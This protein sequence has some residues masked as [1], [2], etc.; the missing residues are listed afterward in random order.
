MS[1][2]RHIPKEPHSLG[3]PPELMTR[4][5]HAAADERRSLS[6]LV[7]EALCQRLGIDPARY[8]I[9]PRKPERKAHAASRQ[10]A[11]DRPA[12]RRP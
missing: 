6:E 4:V 2:F 10:T 11:T 8:G 1:A 3:L 9:T 12:Q 5:R 7:T